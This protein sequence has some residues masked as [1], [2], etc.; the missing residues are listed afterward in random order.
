MFKCHTHKSCHGC[1]QA[2]DRRNFLKNCGA[3]MVAAAGSLTSF[4]ACASEKDQTR[5]R[6]AAVFL[7][8]MNTREIWPYP[9]FDTKNRQRDVL[10]RLREG[11]PEIEL[12]PVAV[13]KA[14]DMQKVIA[15]KDR[16]EGYLVYTMTLVWSHRKEVVDIAGLGKPT[17]V[18]DEFLGGSG[19]F[20][21]GYGELY[22]RKIPVVAVST[23][24]LSDLVLVVQQFAN[25]RKPGTTPARFAQQCEQVYRGSF[26]ADGE[27]KCVGDPVALTNIHKCV[28]RFHRSR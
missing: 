19:V 6:V 10:T 5:I 4:A 9:G 2:V 15:L 12:V 16:V 23:T 7:M 1:C 13:E 8:S 27:L 14:S 3:A 26:P 18:A 24:R 21:T 25:V 28:E 20:L 22:D 17:V 11:C